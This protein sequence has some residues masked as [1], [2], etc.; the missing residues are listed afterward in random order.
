MRSLIY[1]TLSTSPTILASGTGSLTDVYV[2][3]SLGTN[4]VLASPPAPFAIIDERTPST[5]FQVVRKQSRSAAQNFQIR[6]YDLR[7]DYTRIDH[8]INLIRDILLGVEFQVSPSGAR[9]IDV[10][11]MGDTQDG[12]DSELDLI[13]KGVNMRFVSNLTQGE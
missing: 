4:P 13:F 8:T 12:E 11:W 9:C 6:V 1:S 7:G 5:P 10:R 3:N 2:V